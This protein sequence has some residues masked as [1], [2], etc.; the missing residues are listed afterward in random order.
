[1]SRVKQASARR[2]RSAAADWLAS[3]VSEAWTYAP[4]AG[5]VFAASLGVWSLKRVGFLSGR[6]PE[7]HLT[8]LIVIVLALAPIRSAAVAAPLRIVHRTVFILFAAYALAAYPAVSE[9]YVEQSVWTEALHLYGRWVAAAA[10]VAAWFRPSFGLVPVVFVAWKKHLMANQFGFPLNATDYYPVAELGLFAT[11]LI[12]CVAFAERAR[13]WRG[14]AAPDPA[15]WSL[16]EGAFVAVF[17]LHAANYFYSA[18]AKATLPGASFWT[19]V[20]ENDTHDIMLAT[21]AIGL[22]PL[23]SHDMLAWGGHEFMHRFQTV[24]NFI[25]Y[26]SQWAALIALVRLR[27]AIGLTLFYDAIHFAVFLTTSIL[28]WKWMTLNI[29]LVLALEIMRS[30]GRVAPPWPLLTMGAGV[31]LLSPVIFWVAH[32]GWFD[33]KALNRTSVEMVMTD[34]RVVAAPSNFFLEGSAQLAKSS[35]GASFPGHFEDIGV[36]GKAER[37]YDQMVAA[38]SCALPVGEVSGVGR[39][40]RDNPELERYF[41]EHHRFAL[42]QIDED[43]QFRYNIFPHH[44]WSNPSLYEDFAALD[45]RNVETYRY[46]VES[47][48]LDYDDEGGVKETL[49][50]RGAYDIPVR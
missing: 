26:A 8:L 6:E 3:R 1:M 7:L 18:V 22:G 35:I 21:A 49:R 19:W 44:N 5:I 10:A 31:L 14:A 50:L 45:L 23:L 29:G 2:F 28:F 34:G 41:V 9:F 17:S 46:V 20:L 24:T 30:R 4:H 16:G 43:G 13:R 32:L 33:S 42:T 12:G 39:M 36:F 27:F 37:G 47:I 40:F 15:R 48:C 25:T 38:R 11:L